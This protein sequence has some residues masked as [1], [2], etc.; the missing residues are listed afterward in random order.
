MSIDTTVQAV[1]EECAIR[2]HEGSIDF[3]TVVA[4]L[5]AVGV[6]SYHADYRHKETTYYLPGGETYVIK[7]SPPSVSIAGQ[8]DV[9]GIHDAIR[10]AQ[11]GEVRYQ[12]FMR[13][14]MASGC[15]GYI[16]WVAGRHVQYLGRRGEVHTE[17]FPPD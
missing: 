12:E 16:V 1:I 13:L 7:L 10:G 11:C 8:F 14:T 4:K 9:K 17:H 15:I 5:T 3:A 2:S 6:E